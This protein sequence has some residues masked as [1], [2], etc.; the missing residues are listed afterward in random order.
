MEFLTIAIPVW[1]R[2]DYF[3]D[4]LASA[5]AQTVPVQVVVVDNASSHDRFERAVAEIGN[6]RVRYARNPQ[7]LGMYGNWN[8]CG[9]LAA[10][11]FVM[12]LG[13]DDLLHPEFSARVSA[14]VAANPD[15][16]CVYG[17]LERFGT[18]HTEHPPASVPF[19]LVSGLDLLESAARHAPNFPTNAMAVRTEIFARHRFVEAPVALNQ[20]WL[21]AYRA[22][23]DQTAIGIAEPMVRVRVHETGN[24]V[25]VGARAFLSTALV[26]DEI[27]DRLAA[28]GRSEAA[29][30]A[31]RRALNVPRS[32]VIAGHRRELAELLARPDDNPFT[33]HLRA[34][35]A[36]DPWLRLALALPDSLEPLRRNLLRVA[37]RV[38]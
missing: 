2:T 7:N 8:R 20:D 25:Q 24:A 31:R 32:A 11:P 13:D 26:L 34:R 12:I 28:T 21:F 18:K 35:L 5:L 29:H 30:V 36:R 19:G 4:A 14:A 3:G 16:G 17:D 33:P 9:E 22:L 1:E 6:P 27:A 23:A 37:R 38:T 15:L 10:T